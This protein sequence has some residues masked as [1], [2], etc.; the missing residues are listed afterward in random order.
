ML[1]IVLISGCKKPSATHSE[2]N[3]RCIA[4]CT[5]VRVE[6]KM[7][8]EMSALETVL[9]AIPAEKQEKAMTD[10]EVA[11]L[12]EV[13]AGDAL[14]GFDENCR[15]SC[16][17]YWTDEQTACAESMAQPVEGQV[18]HLELPGLKVLTG[19][20]GRESAPIPRTHGPRGPQW[21]RRR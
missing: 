12:V 10:P 11:K 9:Q 6:Y 15:T 2:R 4:A 17:E 5:E 20:R 1:L 16:M 8:A 19:V 3:K 18:C 14:L 13:T 21:I 7:A